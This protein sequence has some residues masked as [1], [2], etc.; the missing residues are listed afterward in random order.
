MGR[1]VKYKTPEEMQSVPDGNVIFLGDL[2]A[3]DF[4][5]EK[6]LSKYIE[7]NISLFCKNNLSDDFVSYTTERPVRGHFRFSP[8]GR[9]IDIHIICK[10]YEYIVELKN[11]T[12]LSENRNGIGQLLDYG[13]EFPYSKKQ[14]LLI[15]SKFDAGTAKTIKYYKLPIRYF[16]INKKQILEYIGEED[17]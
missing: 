1:S 12:G 5:T 16:F 14:L 10:E 17:G 4:K 9:R 6:A 3:K 13:R 8:R 15:S 2:F 7:D 11:P